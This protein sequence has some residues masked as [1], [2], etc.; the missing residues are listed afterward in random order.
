MNTKLNIILFSLMSLAIT[1]FAKEAYTL[2][3]DEKGYSYVQINEDMDAFK[4]DVDWHSVGNSGSIGYFIY[5]NG[6]E[7]QALIDYINEFDANDA[8]FSKHENNGQISFGDVK[9]GDRIGFYLNRKQ[10]GGTLVRGWKFESKNDMYGIMFDKNG[11]YGN[12]S[13]DELILIKGFDYDKPSGAPLPGF[14]PFLLIGGAGVG[15]LGL[16]K[17]KKRS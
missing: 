13:K 3:N 17:S 1:S 10:G 2:V 15:F 16:K 8:R 11:N 4:F 5:P 12:N 14:L 9:E 6:L 7:G